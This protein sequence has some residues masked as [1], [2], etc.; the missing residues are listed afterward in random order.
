MVVPAT[1]PGL[2]LVGVDQSWV[3]QNVH[4]AWLGMYQ[5]SYGGCAGSAQLK[6]HDVTSD[7]GAGAIAKG[8]TGGQADP[9]SSLPPG[10]RP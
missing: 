1:I 8:S 10:W 5:C 6:P 7:R 9:T 3:R 4:F 2:T